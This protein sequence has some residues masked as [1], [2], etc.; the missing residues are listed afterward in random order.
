LSMGFIYGLFLVFQKDIRDYIFNWSIDWHQF[1]CWS[2][3]SY[4]VRFVQ[5][6]GGCQVELQKG[7]NGN[8]VK[9]EEPEPGQSL[10]SRS[11]NETSLTEIHD[12]LDEDHS[13]KDTEDDEE[14]YDSTKKEAGF[15]IIMFYY[16]QDALLLHIGTVYTK[17]VSR[18]EIQMKSFLLAFFRF[19]LDF[20]QFMDDV[21]LFP[22]LQPVP[23]MFFKTLFV[24]YVLV[25]FG[26]FYC[27]HRWWQMVHNYRKSKNT[28]S[29]FRN[30]TPVKSKESF[31]TKLAGG[32]I[33]ALLFTYQKLATTTFTLLN[34]V[35][36]A[37]DSV[38]FIDGTQT[39]FQS[40]QYGV[41]AYA[42]SCVLLFS[43]ILMAGPPL[44]KQ[45]Y[46]SLTEFFFGCL[47][48]LPALIYWFIISQGDRKQRRGTHN[49]ETKTVLQIL[50]GP[51]KDPTSN[52]F[53]NQV[54]WSGVLIGRRL[55]LFL[56]FT[57]INSV[58]V[59][60][61][62]MLGV[63]F[64][65]LLHHVYV[66]PYTSPRGNLAGAL[67]AA[68]LLI[69]GGINLLRAGF[70]AAEYIPQ[71]PNKFLMEVFEEIENTLVLWL[72]LAGMCLIV[73]ILVSRLVATF[74]HRTHIMIYGSRHHVS[75]RAAEV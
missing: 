66:Q 59:R 15:L 41:M 50:Q 69:V 61:L 3:N 20:Y 29:S 25:L 35:P 10:E 42:F 26:I 1:G 23:K 53:L 37:N 74:V 12:K 21:C 40:W 4:I 71:G 36:V 7:V 13:V 65:I 32:F 24:P 58:L 14:E 45:G 33:L 5:N 17:T 48:P 64:I 52:F 57:F 44:L 47:C 30:T 2:Q 38:L 39:C 18:F 68:A 46:I 19:R 51:F 43:V 67:S 63:C 6:T 56:C 73:L 8:C 54:C 75:K 31:S 9:Q 28:M 72:P 70:E 34:C 55:I 60:L 62:C 22:N 11:E 16:F 49:E 27:C